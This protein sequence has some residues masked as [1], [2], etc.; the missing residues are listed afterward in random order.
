VKAQIRKINRRE[1]RSPV[2]QIT[3]LKFPHKEQTGESCVVNKEEER[4]PREKKK[5]E[6]M[7]SGT[8]R[9]NRENDKRPRSQKNRKWQGGKG[10]DGGRLS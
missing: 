8:F 3:S 7:E 6:K 2:S 10:S 5:G 4:R 1:K 9:Q